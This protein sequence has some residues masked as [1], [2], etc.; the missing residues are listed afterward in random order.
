MAKFYGKKRK[1]Q[2]PTELS[3]V[4][5]RTKVILLFENYIDCVGCMCVLYA[6]RKMFDISSKTVYSAEMSL[7]ARA[8]TDTNS[9]QW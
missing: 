9:A 4:K 6:K 3:G 2:N 5:M 1:E 8:H 7:Q